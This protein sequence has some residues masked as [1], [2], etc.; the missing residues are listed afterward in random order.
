M[1][2]FCIVMYRAGSTW[3]YQVVSHLLEKYRGQWIGFADGTVI[4]SGSS[5]VTVFHA[6]ESSGVGSGPSFAGDPYGVLVS[7]QAA[8]RLGSARGLILVKPG[9]P[10]NS[11]LVTKLRSKDPADPVYGPG[12]PAPAPGSICAAAV[13]VIAQWIAQGAPNR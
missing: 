3:Q 11:F 2:V 12:Q 8:N 4:A 13:D 1:L 7:A 10:A 5:P 6:A 9:D